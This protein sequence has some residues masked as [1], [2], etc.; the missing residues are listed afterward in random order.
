MLPKNTLDESAK[1]FDVLTMLIELSLLDGETS[2]VKAVQNVQTIAD[3]LQGKATLP[4]AGQRVNLAK[5]WLIEL[6]EF[7]GPV[8]LLWHFSCLFFCV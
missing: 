3:K 7:I 1:K 6:M 8:N 4:Q 2:C 5:G